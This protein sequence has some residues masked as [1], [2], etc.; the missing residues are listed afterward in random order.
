M[1]GLKIEHNDLP[2]QD[3]C[4]QERGDLKSSLLPHIFE[5]I[6]EAGLDPP[7]PKGRASWKPSFYWLISHIFLIELHFLHS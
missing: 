1:R 3:Q 5:I 2:F 7:I 4:Y 6:G